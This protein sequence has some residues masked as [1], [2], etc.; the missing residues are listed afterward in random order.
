MTLWDQ[1][2]PI[3]YQGNLQEEILHPSKPTLTFTIKLHL[4]ETFQ[5]PNFSVLG[6]WNM[7]TFTG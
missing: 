4:I 5:L 3:F 6:A 2:M 7:K 1:Q